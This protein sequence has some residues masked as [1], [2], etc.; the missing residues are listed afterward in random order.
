MAIIPSNHPNGNRR[1][2]VGIFYKENLPLKIRKDR[3]FSECLVSEV[4]IGKR[5]VFYLVCYRS[6]SMKAY[7]TEFENYLAGFENLF[8]NISKNKPY[9]CFIAGGFNAHSLSWWPNGVTN[10]E[11]LALDNLLTTLDLSQLISEPT[12]FEENK[13]PSCIGLIV[14]YQPNVV[15]GNGVRPSPDNVC[16]PQI[17]FCNLNL[18]IPPPPVYSRNICHYN[19]AN[20]DAM[21]KAVTDFPWINHLRNLE[22]SQQVDLENGIISN[23]SFLALFSIVTNP[24]LPAFGLNSDRKFY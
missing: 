22:P 7:T 12:N 1:G 4:L 19:R 17:T 23:V 13:S 14:C 10:T 11:C 2:G 20:S 8:T 5:K 18:P 21:T 3:S 16:K 15:M 9:A 24:T 6:P